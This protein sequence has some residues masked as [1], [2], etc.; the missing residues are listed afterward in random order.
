MGANLITLAEYKTSQGIE[1]LKNDARLESLITSVSQLVKTYC[2]NSF[3]DYVTTD[4]TESFNLTWTTNSV[5]VS[6]GPLISVTT[7]EE[8]TAYGEDYVELTEVA[9]EFYADL[10]TDSIFRT[11]ETGFIPWKQGPGSMRV[12]YKAGY[13]ELPADLKLAVMDLVTYYYKDEYKPRQNIGGTSKANETTST[14]WRN[15]GFPDHIKRVLDLY[16]QI[17]I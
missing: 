15:V 3:I 9:H 4:F 12:V 11:N 8:R 6:E 16:K 2:A 17:R 7:V 14:Q 10:A 13:T 1:S 5:Q